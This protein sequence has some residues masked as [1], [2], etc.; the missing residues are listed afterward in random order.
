MSQFFSLEE[1]A[2]RYDLYRPAVH[3]VALGW[4]R[5]CVGDK[6]FNSGIDIGCGTGQSTTPLTEVCDNVVGIDCSA[7]M[8]KH[9]EIRGVNTRLIPC[10]ELEEGSQ[11]DLI[12]CCMA[13]HWFDTAKAIQAFKRIS[14]PGATWLIYS[15]AF[16]GHAT[17]VDF[18]SWFKD[19]YLKEYPS[20]PRNRTF[21]VMPTDDAEIQ[22]LAQ[23]Q[24]V[25]SVEF[26]PEQLVGYFTTQSNIEVAVKNG[27]DYEA[28]S[29]S[30]LGQIERFDLSSPF[31][32][33]FSYAIYK[34]T[35]SSVRHH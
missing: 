8:L 1:S 20:P 24:G 18:N 32:Y 5:A 28:I 2:R 29:A 23:E 22:R 21:G 34:F 35:S 17:N 31:E 19:F 7:E 27:A 6:R 11:F 3:D 4:L 15:F 25:L 9:A 10:E 14:A 30:L 26:T 16:Q 13:F 12:S 33:F